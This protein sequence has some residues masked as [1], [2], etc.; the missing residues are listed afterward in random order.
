[1]LNKYRIYAYQAQVPVN[2]PA[3][4]GMDYSDLD[5]KYYRGIECKD[6][7][8]HISRH[9]DKSEMILPNT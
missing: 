9:S 4:G 8:R 7:M 6:T 1:M 2:L 5:S 3:A